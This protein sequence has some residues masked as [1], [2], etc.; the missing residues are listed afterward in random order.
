MENKTGLATDIWKFLA[1]IKLSAVLITTIAATSIIGTFIPQNK[2]LAEYYHAYGERLFVLFYHLGFYDLFSSRWFTALLILLAIN[3]IVCSIE[4]FNKNYKI[5]F[6]KTPAF[7]ESL[8]EKSRAKAEFK[9]EQ[10]PD[11]IKTI[12]TDWLKQRYSYTRVE[13]NEHYVRIFAEK[14]RWSR[15]GVYIIHISVLILLFGGLIGGM[16]G[17]QAFVQIPEGESRSTAKILNSDQ[18]VDFGF[19]VRCDAFSVTFYPSGQPKEYRSDLVILDDGQEVYRKSIIVNDPLRYKGLT[20]YQSSYSPLIPDADYFKDKTISLQFEL[21]ETGFTYIKQAG[22]GQVIELPE[23]MGYFELTGYLPRYIFSNIRDIGP[24]FIGTYTN[25]QGEISEI[26]IPVQHPRFDNM[27]GGEFIV[28][29]HNFQQRFVTGLQV[30]RDPGVP[31]VYWGFVMIIVGFCVTFFFYHQ[32]LRLTIQ[33]HDSGS[34]VVISG[35]SN[36]HETGMVITINKI[37][38]LLAA[39]PTTKA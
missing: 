3:L 26:I 38:K 27:R 35:V 2:A 34:A 19:E 1:S 29:V 15:L 16:F 25:S 12:F 21:R 20:F 6:P 36:R 37:S 14:G 33:Q 17:Y 30:T 28:S 13:N 32:R 39:L 18:E 24:S 31:I 9:L 23:N 22:I 10:Q 7:P 8:F 5:I 4:R 11:Q